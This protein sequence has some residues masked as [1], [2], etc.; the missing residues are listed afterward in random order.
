MGRVLPFVVAFG[1]MVY[2]L[3]DL[4]QTDSARVTSLNKGIWAAIIVLVPIIGPILWL[5][6]AKRDWQAQPS[7]P[8]SPPVA[9]DDNPE[10]LRQIRTIDEE[11]EQMLDD[12]ESDLRKREEEMRRRAEGNGD[13]D[14]RA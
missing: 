4:F 9:P 10:F 7:R 1:L 3:I 8:T 11:H 13:D 2:A 6:V 5:V 14:S 12:W